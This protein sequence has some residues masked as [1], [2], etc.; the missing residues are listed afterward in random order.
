MTTKAAQYWTVE[1]LEAD[2]RARKFHE[3]LYLSPHGLLH[4]FPEVPDQLFVCYEDAE[5]AARDSAH[6][7]KM[8]VQTLNL[9]D[10]AR[11]ARYQRWV[12]EVKPLPPGQA[13][14]EQR[15]TLEDSWALYQQG[16]RIAL[17]ARFTRG[18]VTQLMAKFKTVGWLAEAE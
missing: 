1:I 7:V 4:A 5:K 14:A 15:L 18:H 9:K 17:R 6:H 16:G 13:Y 10:L 8:S 2:G 3:P 11:T 12:K